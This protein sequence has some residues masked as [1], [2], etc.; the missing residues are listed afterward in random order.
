MATG[1]SVRCISGIQLA[2]LV[3]PGTII[4]SSSLLITSFFCSI[5]DE[6]PRVALEEGG[7]G[8]QRRDLGRLKVAVSP[9]TSS[10]CA[11]EP[12][13]TS[14]NDPAPRSAR[15]TRGELAL[16]QICERVALA[17]VLEAGLLQM[18]PH[19]GDLVL[20]ASR[21]PS[22]LTQNITRRLA[23]RLAKEA[24]SSVGASAKPILSSHCPSRSRQVW[25]SA[26]TSA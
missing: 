11:L 15:P 26:V 24:A 19:L 12:S 25:T 6:V 16:H 22:Q 8:L 17:A 18:R 23:A 7:L 4:C 5:L 2:I 3:A 20:D 21:V 9:A 10:S 13:P 14:V 1:A